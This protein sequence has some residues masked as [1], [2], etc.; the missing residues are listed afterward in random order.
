[1]AVHFDLYQTVA[2]AV[3]VYFIGQFIRKKVPFFEKYC[4]PAPVVGGLMF[5]LL[6]LTLNVTGVM[7]VT[8]DDTMRS[9]FMMLFFTSIGF[10][11]SFKVLKAG[12]IKVIMLL[13]VC[14]FLLICQNV[15]GVG[16]AKLF[17][18]NPLIG[19]CT[20]SISMIGGHG[21]AGSFGPLFDSMGVKGASSVAVAA[22]T[23]G[24]VMGGIIGGPVAKR[25]IIK[26]NIETP[27]GHIDATHDIKTNE[28]VQA[29]H[30]QFPAQR[31]LEA[32]SILFLAAGIGGVVTTLIAKTGVTFPGYIGAM[33]V[34]AAIRNI[35]DFTSV[36]TVMDDMIEVLGNVSLLLFLSM[37]LMSL[38]LW[39]LAELAIPMIVMLVA[40]TVIMAAIAYYITFNFMGRDYE[41]A[42][43]CSASCG[44]GMGATPNAIANMQAIT[45]KYGPAPKAFF[46]VPIVGSMFIDFVNGSVLTVFVNFLK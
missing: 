10:T 31:T 14:T 43:M 20:G 37:T 46:V 21:T 17:G 30:L 23:F 1:M 24:L 34:A 36:F 40:Q 42:V 29:K 12:G 19:L 11:A 3:V 45:S 6:T 35:S 26:N 16:L 32:F 27:M 44:F 18:L 41:A 8:M 13:V 9:V 5:A 25:R 39:E 22:A 7:V 33:L 15:V 38:R 4:I 2:M 28:A